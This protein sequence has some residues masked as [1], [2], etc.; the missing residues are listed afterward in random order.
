MDLKGVK[1]TKEQADKFAK[2]SS[3]EDILSLVKDEG[4]ELTE[5]QIEQVS[6]G[7]W[8]DPAGI[9]CPKCG[10][11]LLGVSANEPYSCYWCSYTKG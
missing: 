1:F 4:I 6:G 8:D 9:Y 10:S 7:G 11:M 3:P 2:C 5:E